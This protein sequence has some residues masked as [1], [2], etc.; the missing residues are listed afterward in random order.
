MPG[1]YQERPLL[2]TQLGRNKSEGG[3][4]SQHMVA[5]E[6][7]PAVG[8]TPGKLRDMN[9]A[10]TVRRCFVN[11]V[12]G[13]GRHKNVRQPRRMVAVV[14]VPTKGWTSMAAVTL[15]SGRSRRKAQPEFYCA[16]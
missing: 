10:V 12:G 16:S 14:V 3:C 1:A 7:G 11:L 6:G 4:P 2:L 8:T 13:E 9:G 5:P 15:V